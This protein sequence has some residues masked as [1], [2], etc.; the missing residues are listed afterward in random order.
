MPGSAVL[1]HA[2]AQVFV[3]VQD[4]DRAVRFYQ[5]VLGLQPFLRS[6][7]IAF[8]LCGGTRLMLSRPEGETF[9]GRTPVLYYAV[10]DLEAAWDRLEAAGAEWVDRPHCVAKVGA[11]EHWMAFFRDP[12]AN[13]FALTSERV[14]DTSA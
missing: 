14:V 12:E 2:I 1:P 10:R 8:V 7:T 3:P 11:T 5:D 6:E 4:L 13:L 9:A